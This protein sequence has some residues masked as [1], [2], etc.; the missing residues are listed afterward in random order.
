[1]TP[2]A[3]ARAGVETFLASGESFLRSEGAKSPLFV[4]RLRE[5]G[6]AAF[7]RLGFPAPDEEEWRSTNVGPVA[8]GIFTPSPTVVPARERIEERGRALALDGRL[9]PIAFSDRK[10]TQIVFVDG[11]FSAEWSSTDAL[12][13]GAVFE[14]LSSAFEKRPGLLER[15]L[16][17]HAGSGEHPFVALN[18]AHLR[19]GALLYITKGAAAT[20]PFYVYWV[21]TGASQPPLMVSP[22]TLVILEDAAQATLVEVFVGTGGVTFVNSV[23]EVAL[24]GGAVL[25]QTKLQR[26]GPETLHIGNLR[27]VQEGNSRTRSRVF[28]FGG[29]LV[30]NELSVL[31]A[32]EGAGT[33]LDGLFC[34]SGS[35]HVDN[36]TLIDHAR[37]RGSSQEYYKGIL[38]G[39]ARGAFE[40]RIVVR[41]GARLTDAHQRN[42]NLILSD[43]ALVDS[44]PQL[45]I[46]NNDVKCT[47]GAT[48]GRLD[49]TMVFYL[50]S[51]GLDEAAAR[52]LLTF[53]FGSEVVE[54]VR[55]NE[56]YAYL[57]A[58]LLSWLSHAG[59]APEGA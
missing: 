15:H 37:P 1:M 38:D 22:R 33:A 58:S 9:G 43:T 29:K 39:S 59:A 48:T 41:P 51:R 23:T 30:R 10:K 49:E 44:K 16:G 31:L 56:L 18:T 7:G 6:L 42:R 34:V 4:Q 3:S 21:T 14:P 47:H 27:I 55:T 5:D 12:P 32:G 25:D 19:D 13:A 57:E 40:G 36:H 26:E 2:A 46:Y 28:S 11:R 17:R 45:E 24:A 54:T 53:A 50:R 20:E 52:S 8:R 35:Q